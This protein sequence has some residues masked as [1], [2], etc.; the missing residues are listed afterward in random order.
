M[1]Q[2]VLVDDDVMVLEFMTKMIP[3]QDLGF[4]IIASFHDSL[5]A[6]QYMKTNDFDVLITD[7]GMPHLNG[8]DILG[9]LKE[10]NIKSFNV[11]LS[12]HDEFY[13]AQQALKLDAYDYVLKESM[14]EPVITD[15]L[16]RLIKRMDQELKEKSKNEKIS[17]FL[18]KNNRELKSKFIEKVVDGNVSQNEGWWE[19]QEE[20]LGMN[21]LDEKFTPVLCYID[22]YQDVV[23][24]YKSD[25]ILQF[26]INNII[27][28][29][30]KNY[31]QDIQIFY[32]QGKFFV[33]FRRESNSSQLDDQLMDKAIRNMQE[34]LV[35]FLKITTTIVFGNKFQKK[36]GLITSMQALL[37]N[38]ESRF[39]YEPN[40]IQALKLFTF[41]EKNIFDD[42]Q[43]VLQ[44]MKTFIIEKEED[45]VFSHIQANICRIKKEKFHPKMVLDFAV[46]IVLDVKLSLNTLMRFEDDQLLQMTNKITKEIDTITH[47]EKT[48]IEICTLFLKHVQ[49]FNQ[50]PRNEEVLK[51]Q[52]YVRQHLH[53]KISL[54][55]VAA[56]LHLNASYF[57][58]LFKQE[59]GE[60]FIEYVTRIKMEIAKDNLENTT[61]STDQIAMELGF[62]S[63]SY[64]LKT[65]KKQ[66][67][68]APK[69]YKYKST[70]LS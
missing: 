55:D 1:Y 6:L 57:S 34:K 52:K 4:E 14:E 38:E 36:Q 7:I 68:M 66:T 56:Y 8:I 32:L 28:E 10:E 21:F 43:E 18:N 22:Y 35:T 15:L 45:N 42:Y 64:F 47:L 63:K 69:H 23:E 50:I 2:V 54:K 29:E 37:D 58:R 41:S 67:G 44:E 26:S 40:S 17:R 61:K 3:W 33:L 20:L 65:F 19:E 48:L 9:I 5:E 49:E 11:I 16:T 70:S 31:Q 39:Y 13:Y 12:C 24:K 53:Q 60:N 51:A 27:E 59:T 25:T 46:K 30:L 62:E